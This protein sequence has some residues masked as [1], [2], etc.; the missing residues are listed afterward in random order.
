[1]LIVDQDISCDFDSNL[2]GWTNSA[3]DDFDWER[4][5]GPTPSDNTGPTMDHTSGRG[6]CTVYKEYITMVVVCIC[7]FVCIQQ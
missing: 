5:S 6:K 2:C 3:S 4:E 1:L 7:S